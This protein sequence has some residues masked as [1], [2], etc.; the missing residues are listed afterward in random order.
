MKA[1]SA[2]FP[3]VVVRTLEVNVR[4]FVLL[5]Q[6]VHTTDQCPAWEGT[7]Q[8]SLD[9]CRCMA[10]LVARIV[11]NSYSRFQIYSRLPQT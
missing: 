7:Q 2:G 1:S 3:S 9:A 5:P 6:T 4:S 10:L 11:E 8:Y